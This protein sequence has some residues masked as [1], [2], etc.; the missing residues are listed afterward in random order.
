MEKTS[1]L[2]RFIDHFS[3][4]FLLARLLLIAFV[5]WFICSNNIDEWLLNHE[6]FVLLISHRFRGDEKQF[7][8]FLNDI[9]QL[10]H[11]VDLI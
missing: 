6:N 11:C 4:F 10:L 3:A 8:L 5:D 9:G 2:S 1:L 7:F